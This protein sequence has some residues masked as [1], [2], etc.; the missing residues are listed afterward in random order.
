MDRRL[1]PHYLFDEEMTICACSSQQ[2]AMKQLLGAIKEKQRDM[3]SGDDE[4]NQSHWN[5]DMTVR[6]LT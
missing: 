5:E 3:T 2:L 4:S 6:S 1:W